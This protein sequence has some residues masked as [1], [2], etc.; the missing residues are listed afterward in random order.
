MQNALY[1]GKLNSCQYHVECGFGRAYLRQPSTK[2]KRLSQLGMLCFDHFPEGAKLKPLS[3]TAGVDQGEKTICWPHYLWSSLAIH[4]KLKHPGRDGPFKNLARVM[5]RKN[6]GRL[7]KF[8]LLW[9]RSI[10][11][12]NFP[13]GSFNFIYVSGLMSFLLPDRGLGRSD[14]LLNQKFQM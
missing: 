4:L 9:L 10:L 5:S 1:S 12:W 13:A 11:S 6:G 3:K 2:L 8:Q 14:H 7:Y